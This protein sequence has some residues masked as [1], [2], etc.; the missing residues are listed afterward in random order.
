MGRISPE[1]DRAYPCMGLVVKVPDLADVGADRFNG[2]EREPLV[3][4]VRPLRLA[5]F[6]PAEVVA[7]NAVLNKKGFPLKSFHRRGN[8]DRHGSAGA[9]L[10]G[11][12]GC[13]SG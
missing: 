11:G 10:C 8:R 4:V 12:S 9:G 7:G 2:A 13:R 5:V 3:R 1:G 6:N